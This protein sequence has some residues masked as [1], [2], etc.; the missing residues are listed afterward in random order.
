VLEPATIPRS[1]CRIAVNASTV[2]YIDRRAMR[3]PANT[4]VT[5]HRHD[6][7]LV[8][9]TVANQTAHSSVPASVA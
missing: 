2:L 4:T 9:Y 7:R 3:L 8:E 1:G 5:V 6:H